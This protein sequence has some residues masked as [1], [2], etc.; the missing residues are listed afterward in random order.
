MDRLGLPLALIVASGLTLAAQQVTQTFEVAS[1]KPQ[2]DPDPPRGVSSP[3]RFI[4]PDSTLLSLIEYGYELTA[5]QIVGGPEWVA[6]RR[7][8]VDAKA[9]GAPSRAEMRLLVRALLAQRF[10][11]TVHNETRDLPVYLLERVRPNGPLGPALRATSGSE[12][13]ALVV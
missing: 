9:T 2:S 7:F 6:S 5:T 8:A 3:D 10:N 13:T 4:Y 1:I 11:L 12:C